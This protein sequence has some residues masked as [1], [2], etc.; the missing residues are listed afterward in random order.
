MGALSACIGGFAEHKMEIDALNTASTMGS[1]H[2]HQHEARRLRGGGAFGVGPV[3]VPF[4]LFTSVP[5]S[6]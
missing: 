1:Q 5:L 2:D 3:P 4:R 6:S